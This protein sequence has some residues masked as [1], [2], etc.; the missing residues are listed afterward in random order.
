MED[1]FDEEDAYIDLESV[2]NNLVTGE[3]FRKLAAALPRAL[4]YDP[5]SSIESIRKA[6]NLSD[7]V[8]TA[9]SFDIKFDVEWDL[10]AFMHAQYGQNWPTLGSVVVLTGTALY[11]Q[12]TTYLLY[13]TSTWSD[14]G[15]FFLDLLLQAGLAGGRISRPAFNPPIHVSI[16]VTDFKC[17]VTLEVQ[18]ANEK[19][20]HELAELL[21]WSSP[22]L[23]LS[24][25]ENKLVYAKPSLTSVAEG[26]YR[27]KI[28]HDELQDTETAC[29]QPLFSGAVIA[30]GFPTPAHGVEVGMEA[31]LDILAALGGVRHAIEYEGGIVLKGF[32]HMFIPLR[33]EDNRVQWHAISSQHSQRRLTYYDAVASCKTRVSIEEVTFEDLAR[34]RHFLG[35]CSVAELRL[36]SHLADYENL[37]YSI[38]R[39]AKPP[40]RCTGAHL[41]IQNIGAGVIDFKIGPKDGTFHFQRE[42]PYKKV[43]N[44]AEQTRVVL[45]DTGGGM[46][47]GHNQNVDSCHGKRAWLVP[48]SAAMLHMAQHRHS[49]D[50]IKVGGKPA[51][52]DTDIP[53][54]SLAKDVLL[55]FERR[56]APDHQKIHEGIAM[57]APTCDIL[58]GYEFRAIVRE[59]LPMS[60][61]E[62][63]LNKTNGGWPEL[64]K[65]INALVLF[66]NGFGDLILPSTKDKHRVC[67]CWQR[68]KT[69]QDHLATGIKATRCS[70]RNAV[71][72]ATAATVSKRI[73]TRR[74]LGSIVTPKKLEHSGAVM[75]G[76]SELACRQDFQFGRTSNKSQTLYSQPNVLIIPSSSAQASDTATESSESST[77]PTKPQ[78][79]SD[80]SGA[81][82]TTAITLPDES[83]T[84]VEHADVVT[85]KR[86]C[87]PDFNPAGF[88]SSHSQEHSVIADAPHGNLDAGTRKRKNTLDLLEIHFP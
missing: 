47:A 85:I 22:A 12:A 76:R 74:R 84:S 54:G 25:L 65:D 40:A 3:A 21:A 46:S 19:V 10:N 78:M 80:F 36:G 62:V 11:V 28:T 69:G 9:P 24:P 67:R 13:V 52:L 81:S 23:R 70:S 59:Q 14:T 18:G 87:S 66:A 50:P 32:S 56:D 41:D 64:V 27:M 2:H 86:S 38:A 37:D 68:L 20:L 6:L 57:Q 71:E 8:Y 45:Y 73:V 42:G 30:S 79:D 43:A 88:G 31:P 63:D 34:C 53:V 49:M 7:G 58:T 75:F 82:S 60:L 15:T 44:W 83:R 51:T 1:E 17:G 61:K 77:T 29:W 55:Q 48:A 33:K 26:H 72:I 4:Y 39:V 16:E 5:T 35:W